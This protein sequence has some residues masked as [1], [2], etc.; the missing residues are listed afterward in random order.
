M[1]NS[2]KFK[3]WLDVNENTPFPIKLLVLDNCALSAIIYSCEVWGNLSRLKQKLQKIELNLL[4]SALGVKQGTPNNIVYNELKRGSIVS[5]IKDCQAKF[6]DKVENLDEQECL[7]KCVWNF[8]QS[9][10]LEYP[11]Y[12]DEL[13]ND[14][15]KRDI[16]ERTTTL[17]ESNKTMDVRYR[18]LIGLPGKHVLYD[19]YTSDYSRKLITRWRLSNTKLAIE[20]GRY[21]KKERKDRLCKTCLVIE[22]EHHALFDC[23]NYTHIRT[24]HQTYFTKN[25]TVTLFMNPQT[26]EDIYETAEILQKIEEQHKKYS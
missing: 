23:I 6:I 8:C 2:G 17:Q 19:P 7:A 22:D 15:C 12:H 20:T 25:N 11:Q 18:D 10:D 4:K 13:S 21:T 14:N 3:S 16:E 26:T 5:R 9:L 24:Q 1:Y